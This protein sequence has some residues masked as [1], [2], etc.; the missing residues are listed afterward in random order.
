[1]TTRLNRRD[2]LLGLTALLLGGLRVD[3]PVPAILGSIVA[4]V[5]RELTVPPGIHDDVA[6]YARET[7][8][9]AHNAAGTLPTEQGQALL[10]NA[11]SAFTD[12]LAVAAGVGSAL[13]LASAITIWLLL[14][15]QQPPR[16]STQRRRRA[17]GIVGNVKAP[18]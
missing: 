5:Y 6:T 1:M 17:A 10:T 15:P 4:A 16:V 3:G 9:A 2:A 7:L 12:G 18:E 8:G 11:Q 14:K 13:L